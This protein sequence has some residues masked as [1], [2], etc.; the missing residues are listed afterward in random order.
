MIKLQHYTAWLIAPV[1]LFHTLSLKAQTTTQSSAT[2]S[3]PTACN[4]LRGQTTGV[5]QRLNQYSK[6]VSGRQC[7]VL[8]ANPAD[9]LSELIKQIPE[10]TVILLSSN[11]TAPTV[12]PATGIIPVKYFIGRE[13]VLKDGHDILGAAD[14]GFIIVITFHSYYQKKE[15]I[16][17]GTTD[18]FQFEKTRDS[19]IRHITFLST[20]PKHHRPVNTIIF[21]ECYNRRLIVKDNFFFLPK[22]AAVYIDCKEPLNA[23]ANATRPGP[24]L[25]FA[26]NT[27]RVDTVSAMHHGTIPDGGVYINLPNIMNHS[28]RVAV[29]GNLFVGKMA[30]AGEFNLGPGASMD[31]FRNRAVIYIAEGQPQRG[32]VLTGYANTDAERP[33][34]NLAGNQIY[35]TGTAITVS[36][37]LTLALACNQLQAVNPW[38]QLQ[39]QFILKAADPLPLAAECETFVSS[40]VLLPTP[41]SAAVTATLILFSNGH[42]MNTWAAINNSPATACSGLINFEGPFFFDS[43]ICQTAI[44]SPASITDTASINAAFPSFSAGTTAVT[45]GLAVITTLAILLTL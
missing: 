3:L 2:T 28:K 35:V 33:L 38:R 36:T 23:S 5:S 11:T 20:G 41:G 30:Y 37:P 1:F 45:T 14:D 12:T 31:V 26:N 18:N 29:I 21:A 34:F 9:D 24:G 19:H 7:I 40:T 10:N 17:A 16:R 27:L 42:V 6:L 32:F 22:S 13:I 8:T 15:M 4:S 44:R 39:P 25:L 43:D